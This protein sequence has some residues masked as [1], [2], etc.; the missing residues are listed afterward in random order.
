MVS[1][2]VVLEYMHFID[3]Y[4]DVAGYDDDGCMKLNRVW[5]FGNMRAIWL[6]HGM[7]LKG[8]WT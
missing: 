3:G 4:L 2:L 7:K 6:Y 5:S 1:L 8:T